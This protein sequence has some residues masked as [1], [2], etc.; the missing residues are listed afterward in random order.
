MLLKATVTENPIFFKKLCLLQKQ[1]NLTPVKYELGYLRMT[2][3]EGIPHIVPG[4]S[5][6]NRTFFLKKKKIQPTNLAVMAHLLYILWEHLKNFK[7]KIKVNGCIRTKKEDKHRHAFCIVTTN[8][9]GFKYRI[10]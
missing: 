3:K 4:L 1:I 10:S 9:G 7:T 2:L 5:G 6:D 8:L